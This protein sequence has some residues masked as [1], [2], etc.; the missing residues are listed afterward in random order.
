MDSINIACT[1]DNGY[2]QHFAALMA[3]VYENNRLN[4]ICFY[5]VTNFIDKTNK[6]KLDILAKKYGK[7]IQ[8]YIVDEKRFKGLPYGGK[9]PHISIASYFRLLLSEVLP[10]NISKVLYLDCDI[11][12]MDNLKDLWET[13]LTDVALAGMEDCTLM[14]KLGPSR[15]GYPSDYSYFNA[16]VLLLNLDYLRKIN[17][18]GMFAEYV[19]LN[20]DKILYHDQDILNALL[21]NKK[22]FLPVKWNVMD[23][24]MF[25]RPLIDRKYLSDLKKAK[26]S[27]SII[28][29]S[30]RRKPWYKECTHPYRDLYWKYLLLTEYGKEQPQMLFTTKF[31]KLSYKIKIIVKW[32]VDYL[33][34]DSY[35]YD[36]HIPQNRRI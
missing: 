20:Y 32:I 8:F 3:S 35:L 23:C 7:K 17:F 14:T 33:H 12:V 34:M 13:D 28:H 5:L 10:I 19:V 21:F 22:R 31:S 15:L 16:G 36:S 25:R 29:Y 24:F 11:I 1:C 2:C 4:D 18:V 9:F 30:G 6:E 27:P 26:M